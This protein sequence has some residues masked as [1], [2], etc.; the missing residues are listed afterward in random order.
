MPRRY[1]G[2]HAAGDAPASRNV[3]ALPEPAR[4]WRLLF[5]CVENSNRSQMAEAFARILG[6]ERVAAYSAGSRP[7]GRVSPRAIE[8][9][10]EVGYDLSVHRSK[11]VSEVPRG[12]YDAVVSMGCGDACEFVKAR[13]RED[14]GIADPKHL[15][16]VGLAVVRDQIRRR[17][18]VL[19][20][21]LNRGPRMVV[22]A[23][24]P[25]PRTWPND[26]GEPARC[27]KGTS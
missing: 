13:R 8:S 25:L 10:K 22:P 14:W 24:S 26:S 21:D 19:L 1:P 9:M 15:D 11:P 4:R 6:G 2:T 17:V 5:L 3:R 16:A 18:E 12:G 20:S 27:R 7:S 23:R